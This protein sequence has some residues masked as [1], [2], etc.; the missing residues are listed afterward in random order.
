M[1]AGQQL[2]H[3]WVEQRSLSYFHLLS[4]ACECIFIPF[5]L[6]PTVGEPNTEVG[7]SEERLRCPKFTLGY[8]DS[9]GLNG[10]CKEQEWP[11]P[12]QL[13]CDYSGW[14]CI[15]ADVERALL[16]ARN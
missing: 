16:S 11:H 14:H 2:H 8:M 4:D 7:T 12:Q 9:L 5:L 13:W 6:E 3:W 10:A 1:T 15:D